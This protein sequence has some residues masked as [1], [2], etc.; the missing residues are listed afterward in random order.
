M[1]GVVNKLCKTKQPLATSF[2]GRLLCNLGLSEVVLLLLFFSWAGD[3]RN[4]ERVAIEMS[5]N[6]RLVFDVF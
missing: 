1:S 6:R 3:V 5:G 4:C 2:A